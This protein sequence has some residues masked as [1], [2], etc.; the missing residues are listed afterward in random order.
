MPQLLG[1][2][3]FGALLSS[4]AAIIQRASKAARRWAGGG[5]AV[6]AAACTASCV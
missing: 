4:I 6:G 3:F 5:E 1:I 2:M